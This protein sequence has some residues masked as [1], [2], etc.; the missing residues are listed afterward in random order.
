MAIDRQAITD[1]I[2]L[3][4]GC[5]RTRSALPTVVGYRPGAC[6]RWCEYHPD[7]AKELL[8][9]AGFDTGAPVDILVQRGRRPRRLDDRGGNMFRKIGLTYR[10]RGNL[11]FNEFLSETRRQGMTGPFRLGWVMDYPSI[12]NF[13]APQYATDAPPADTTFCQQYGVR[14]HPRR[15]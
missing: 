14:R 13:L 3:A 1:A 8:A 9:E 15:R 4:P 5:P 2:F 6:G 7:E 11:Q 12:Q 10:L